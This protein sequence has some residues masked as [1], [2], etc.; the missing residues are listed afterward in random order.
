MAAGVTAVGSRPHVCA[1]ALLAMASRAVSGVR[2]LPWR[3]GTRPRRPCGSALLAPGLH[4]EAGFDVRR[5]ILTGL[6]AVAVACLAA[7][8]LP[9]SATAGAA[10]GRPNIVLV[11][12]DDQRWDTL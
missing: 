8:A 2:P 7:A 12:T 3:L 4:S 5:R 1:P 9:A 6:A 11:L 10:A